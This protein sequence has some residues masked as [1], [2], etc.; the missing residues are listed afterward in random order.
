MTEKYW[1]EDL[2]RTVRDGQ[3]IVFQGQ[4]SGRPELAKI[5]QATAKNNGG[6]H[7]AHESSTPQALTVSA[8][9]C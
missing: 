7:E 4:S 6:Q 9:I 1:S 5:N 2:E 3:S 8:Y